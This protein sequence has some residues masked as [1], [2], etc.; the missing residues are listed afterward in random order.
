ME[1]QQIVVKEGAF[2]IP[3]VRRLVDCSSCRRF[4]EAERWML[5]RKS[6]NGV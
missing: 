1:G 4:R 2:R 3:D 6:F 5:E